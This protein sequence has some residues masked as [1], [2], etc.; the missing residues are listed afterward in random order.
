MAKDVQP[1]PEEQPI[2]EFDNQN[3]EPQ[4]TDFGLIA[5]KTVES[6]MKQSYLDYA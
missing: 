4:K 2:L 5:P 1:T 6:E 3:F